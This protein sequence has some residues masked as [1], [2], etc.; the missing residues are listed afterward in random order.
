[1]QIHLTFCTDALCLPM[2]H[3]QAIQGMLY[4][5]LESDWEYQ[6]FLHNQGYSDGIRQFKAFTFSNLQGPFT[7]TDGQMTFR[8]PVNLEIRSADPH[9]IQ[10]LL[11][12]FDTGAS[13]HLLRNELTVMNCQLDDRHILG[14][15]IDIQM[16]S[17]AV[18]YRTEETKTV[19]FS[20]ADREFYSMIATNAARKWES[21]YGYPIPGSLTIEPL[22]TENSF[23]KVVTRF[24]QTYITGWKGSFRL[25]GC[26]PML[27]LLYQ[28]GLG[29][30]N[31]QGFGMFEVL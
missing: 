16:L 17:P 7:I 28:T 1:M 9:F 31:S 13:C 6:T 2:A 27:D 20:P 26:A 24:K 11:R 3:Q 8:G 4:H 25:C 19:F 14:D 15:C 12:H 29:A 21:V 5:A 18:V 22:P 23:R 30:K 10:L